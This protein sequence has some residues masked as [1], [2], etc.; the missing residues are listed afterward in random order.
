MLTALTYLLTCFCPQLMEFANGKIVLVLE[1][2]YNLHSL[3]KSVLACVKVLLEDKPIDGS[4][5]AYPF[6]ST[7]RIIKAV[8]WLKFF[9][10]SQ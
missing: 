5:E 3:A 8:K 7:W 9:C 4:F 2:G 10:L 1:G 6:E